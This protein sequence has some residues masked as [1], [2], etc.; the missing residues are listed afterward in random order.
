MV[1]VRASVSS[2]PTSPQRPDYLTTLGLRP[3]VSEADVKQA[4]L[5]KVKVAHP[6]RG[7]NLQSFN[8]LQQAYEQSLHYVQFGQGRT[9]WLR[10][11]VDRYI[12]SEKVIAEVKR[13]GG[14]VE[15]ETIDWLKGEIGEDFAQMVERI[16]A[17]RVHDSMVDDR[18]LEFLAQHHEAL[19]SLTEID[20]SDT[21]V[22]SAGVIRLR[23]FHYLRRL[24]LRRTKVDNSALV[25]LN[26]LRSLEW[27]ALNQTR[28]N[29]IGRL[30]LGLSRP[31]LQVATDSGNAQRASLPLYRFL[32][33]LCATYVAIMFLLTHIPLGRVAAPD[34]GIPLDKVVH[35]GMYAGLG[36][37]ARALLT[38]R[39]STPRRRVW[40]K[41]ILAVAGLWLLIAVYGLAD[42]VSQP[43][44][45]RGFE[46]LD[47]LADLIG[48]SV[49]LLG[50]VL[51]RRLVRVLAPGIW[52]LSEAELEA[53]DHRRALRRLLASAVD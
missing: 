35:L 37:L 45:G 5:E 50:F 29:W 36:F 34:F 31:Y 22:T 18:F 38:V 33:I 4:F 24:D 2:E 15:V 48:V 10:T 1:S 3:P 40:T 42:E 9:E 21:K 25:V 52:R 14:T 6:D 11:T 19:Q 16:I 30:Q 41:R 7:G 43:F 44:V 26:S 8:R 23:A 49:G 32:A 47:W 12:E 51:F 46:W 13:L 39:A 20:L 28:V 17:I 53:I 27:I